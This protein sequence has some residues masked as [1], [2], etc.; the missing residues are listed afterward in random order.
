MMFLL[1]AESKVLIL[2]VWANQEI[3]KGCKEYLARI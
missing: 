3:R 1:S 2:F